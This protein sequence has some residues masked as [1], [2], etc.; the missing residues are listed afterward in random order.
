MARLAAAVKAV[1]RSRSHRHDNDLVFAL[2]FS[3]ADLDPMVHILLRRCCMLRRTL[4]KRPQAKNI[5][6]TIMQLYR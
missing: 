3:G 5:A 2:G 4:A 6:D 1:V